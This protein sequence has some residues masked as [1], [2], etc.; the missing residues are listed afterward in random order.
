MPVAEITRG[1]FASTASLLNLACRAIF[2]DTSSTYFESDAADAQAELETASAEEARAAAAAA[3]AA[4]GGPEEAA[5]RRC[6]MP[7]K[8]E[9]PDLTQVMIGMAVTREG[10]P[11]RCWTFPGS[12][13]DQLVIRTMHDDPAGRCTETRGARCAGAREPRRLP[14][15]ADRR[16]RLLA[17]AAP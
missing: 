3:G 7:Y 15:R 1:V 17:A 12:A 4:Q 14:R 16:L 2:V 8:D 5:V 9:R 10:I 11:V 6:S 13:S